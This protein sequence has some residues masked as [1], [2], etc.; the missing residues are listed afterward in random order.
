MSGKRKLDALQFNRLRCLLAIISCTLL[1]I[2]V[3]LGVCE[4]LVFNP[5]SDFPEQGWKSYHLFTILSNMLMAVSAAMCIPYAVDGMRNHNYHLPRWYVDLMYMGVTS[6]TITFV[7]AI[8]ILSS[9]R[10]F[11]QIMLWSNN[12]LLHTLGPVLAMLIFFLIN[13]DH[14]ISFRKTFLAMGPVT[15][16]G[17]VYIIMVFLIGEEAGGWRDHY[18]VS[19]VTDY[20]PVPVAFLVLLLLAFGLATALRVIHNAIHKKN[21][22]GLEEYYRTTDA[23]SYPDIESAIRA[24]ADFSRPLDKGGELT[25]P[26]RAMTILEKKYKSG[27]SMEEMS[28]IYLREYYSETT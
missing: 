25:L 4:Q 7:I 13:S 20:V 9:A 10:G 26:R 18:E 1:C 6:V 24:L 8:T 3:F 16:Y 5:E 15:V 19:T 22:A 2:V 14:R 28:N 21:K 23:F 11:Y 12:F 27:L 17:L